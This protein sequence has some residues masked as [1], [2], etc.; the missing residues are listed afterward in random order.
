MKLFRYILTI[1]IIISQ[2]ISDEITITE[3]SSPFTIDTKTPEIEILF[4]NIDITEIEFNLPGFN[5]NPTN[6]NND[7]F[8]VV[9][10][11][12]GASNLD[13]A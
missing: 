4:S 11:P 2:I 9:S 1:V 12:G 6:I 8:N 3:F 10:M 5:L 7:I 13:L